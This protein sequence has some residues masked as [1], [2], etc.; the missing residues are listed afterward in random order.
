MKSPTLLS[1]RHVL[2][3]LGACLSLPL[4]DAML[5]RA[6]ARPSTYEPLANSLGVQP[7]MICCYIPNGVNIMEWVPETSGKDYQLSKSLETLK[8]VRE[9]FTVISGMGHPGSKGGHSGA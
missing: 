4:L 7:R 3:G 8:D 5:P 6:E 1:R 2:R 9:D